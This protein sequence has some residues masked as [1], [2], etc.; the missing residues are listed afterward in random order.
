MAPA[1]LL[2]IA[3]ACNALAQVS[4]DCGKCATQECVS[5]GQGWARFKKCVCVPSLE[6]CQGGTPITSISTQIQKAERCIDSV[7]SCALDEIKGYLPNLDTQICDTVESQRKFEEGDWKAYYGPRVWDSEALGTII[8]LYFPATSALAAAKLVR[9]RLGVCAA[10]CHMSDVQLLSACNW[11]DDELN[12]QVQGLE[13]ALDTALEDAQDQ[14]RSSTLG[15]EP[16]CA[17]G[18]LSTLLSC[19]RHRQSMHPLCIA[20]MT[21]ACLLADGER[22]Y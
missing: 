13:L 9:V 3:L 8:G 4:A 18:A 22:I 15:A 10:G 6:N 19:L 7:Y 2:L 5:G 21:H 1:A 11:Q 12:K 20:C 16:A 14:V 17:S